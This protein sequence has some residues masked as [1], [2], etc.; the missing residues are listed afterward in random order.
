MGEASDQ[1]RVQRVSATQITLF[2]ECERKWAFRYLLGIKHPQHPAAALGT[3]VDDEQL[4][5]YLREG[6]PIDF[7]RPS[8]SGDIANSG[9]VH[10]PP[11][12]CAKPLEPFGFSASGIEVQRHFVIPS[13]TWTEG[14]HVGFGFQGYMDL[15][16]P[17]DTP[18]VKDFKTSKD[19]RYSKSEDKQ[20][21]LYLGKD[22]QAMLYATAAMYETGAREVDL[23]WIYM[24]TK[25]PRDSKRVHLRVVADQVAEQFSAIN[26]TAL[27]MYVA[28][29]TA[30]DPLELA[31]NPDMCGSYG[32]C[33]HQADCNLSPS[34]KVDALAATH[35]ARSK[36]LPSMNTNIL[37]ENLRKKKA[38]AELHGLP[39][40]G[41]P[42]PE[43]AK[44]EAITQ[45]K[46]EIIAT[47]PVDPLV[48][49][50]AV[51]INP[52]EALLPP[53]PAP[54]RGRPRKEEGVEAPRTYDSAGNAT[55]T[56]TWAQETV[57]PVPFN[58][59]VIGP[60]SVTG[61]VQPGESIADAQARLY[62]PLALFAELTR[63]TKA[64]S[65][66]AFLT[67]TG[68]VK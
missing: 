14:K 11:I 31:P 47:A 50:K 43:V 25:G 12:G 37:L 24:R 51:G 20:S 66:K 60:F 40:A 56:V 19:F 38:E 1:G 55:V 59:M 42:H 52:P 18:N 6:R 36:E 35:R 39:G 49:R 54:K 2:R 30:K 3:E 33:P 5:P 63:A 48:Q 61:P 7:S 23:D 16:I 34:E 53:P 27:R 10:L 32:G 28:R 22:V 64:L 8:G 62:A 58:T 44:I 46:I 57:S 13:P 65:F 41:T 15:W 68:V 17:L 21:T 4:Q 45:A 67:Q 29:K 26:D 9:L